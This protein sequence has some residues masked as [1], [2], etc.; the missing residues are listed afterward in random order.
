MANYIRPSAYTDNPVTNWAN[1]VQKVVNSNNVIAGNG[2]YINNR[3]S[4]GTSIVAAPQYEINHLTYRGTYDIDTEYKVNDVVFVDPNKTYYDSGSSKTL[5]IDSSYISGYSVAPICA[6]L[7]VCTQY[8]PPSFANTTYLE[9]QLAPIYNSVYPYNV[10]TG[11][12]YNSYNVYYPVY[13]TIATS[14]TSSILTT[15][16]YNITANDTFWAP[17]NPMIRMQTCTNGVNATTYIGGIV[18]GSSFNSS[19]LPYKKP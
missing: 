13:P 15:Y 7:F 3:G 5:N 12:R 1:N 18:S 4:A 8:V 19:Y 9:T 10:Q 14:Q 16:G 2:L 17:L 11:I 6:G